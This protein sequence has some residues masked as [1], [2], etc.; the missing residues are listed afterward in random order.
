MKVSVWG[1]RIESPTKEGREGAVWS[2][3]LN[4]VLGSSWILSGGVLFIPLNVGYC[5]DSS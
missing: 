4:Q 5:Q 2:R 1:E 3:E